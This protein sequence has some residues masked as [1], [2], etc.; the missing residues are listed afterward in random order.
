MIAFTLLL[1][2]WRGHTTIP[3]SLAIFPG[4]FGNGVAYSAVFIGLTSGVAEEDIAIAGSGLYLS[5]NVGAVGGV[6][7]ASAVFQIALQKALRKALSGV[8]GVDNVGLSLN[9]QMTLY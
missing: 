1:T 8:D 5:G 7:G 9:V 2:L 6:S 4:G 3:E